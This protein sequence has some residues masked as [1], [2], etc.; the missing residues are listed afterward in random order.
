MNYNQEK[1]EEIISFLNTND[2]LINRLTDEQVD[3]LIKYLKYKIKQKQELLE[4]LKN[5]VE[6]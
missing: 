4:E 5:N 6:S 3:I 2:E 1:L